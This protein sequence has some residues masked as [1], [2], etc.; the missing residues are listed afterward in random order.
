V[1]SLGSSRRSPDRIVDL[2]CGTGASGAA[3]A[4]EREPRP[5]IQGFDRSP[6]ALEEARR[7]L[8]AIGLRGKGRRV[9]VGRVRFGGA[10]EAILAAFTVNELA[11]EIRGRLLSGMLE[12]PGR[13]PSF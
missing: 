7:T 13:G 9:D 4:L 3:W 11:P 12:A 10:G 1:R 6:W 8:A 5:F 2:G